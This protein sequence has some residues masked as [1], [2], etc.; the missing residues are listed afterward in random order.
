M[1]DKATTES[2]GGK[3]GGRAPPVLNPEANTAVRNLT[4]EA[5]A[6]LGLAFAS[7]ALQ[8]AL[9]ASGRHVPLPLWVLLPALLV[10]DFLTMVFALA[11]MARFDLAGGIARVYKPWP[12]AREVVEQPGP[13][14]E[15]GPGGGIAPRWFNW[16]DALFRRSSRKEDDWV[17][18]R[19]RRISPYRYIPVVVIALL[20]LG[21]TNYLVLIG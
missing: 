16:E 5:G 9:V 6:F 19:L 21:L 2:G 3:A 18:R 20:A 8:L 12:S 15:P 13:D 7:Y 4:Q 14:D 17:A 11:T 10:S 1:G